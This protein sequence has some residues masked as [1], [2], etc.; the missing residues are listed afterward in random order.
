[1]ESQQQSHYERLNDKQRLFVDLFCQYRN[2]SRAAREA[3]YSDVRSDQSGYQLLRNIEVSAAVAE[4]FDKFSMSANEIIG[5]MSAMGRGT[6]DYFL[7]DDG[8]LT[9]TSQT[10]VDNR[11]IVK[12]VR[13]RTTTRTLP[14]GVKIEDASIEIELHDAKDAMFKLL[15]VGGKII[16]R[17]EHTG[18]NGGPIKSE[19]RTVHI[20]DHTDGHRVPAADEDYSG[21]GQLK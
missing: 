4:E 12:K 17:H 1:M 20:V 8:R 6:I 2:A 9:L 16:E 7:D 21:S 15:Q 5:R 14:D 3:G 13:Q 18:A 10:A 19:S 11:D